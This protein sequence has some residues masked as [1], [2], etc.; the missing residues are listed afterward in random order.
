MISNENEVR[1]ALQIE[2]EQG[3]FDADELNQITL[4]LMRSLEDVGV[5]SATL[6]R[7]PGS[8]KGA[9]GDPITIGMLLVA[10]LPTVLPKVIEFL[11]TWVVRNNGHTIKAKV[12]QGD[13]SA[14]IEFSENIPLE[15]LQKHLEMIK[16]MVKD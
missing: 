9:K 2:N 16:H 1:V 10:V 3:E 5:E 4:T 8:L 15:K 11:Q 12:Q 6:M 14:E 7:E 13:R